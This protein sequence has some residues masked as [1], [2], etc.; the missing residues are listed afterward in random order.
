MPAGGDRILASDATLLEEY[1]IRKPL[2]RLI[3]QTAQSLAHNTQTAIQYGTSSESIDTH[4]WHDTSV[5][6]TRIT[7]QFAGYFTIRVHTHMATA[8]GTNYTQVTASIAVNG[9]RVDPQFFMRPDAASNSG[10]TAASFT[11]IQLAAGDYVEHFAS[12]TNGTSSAQN[13]SASAGFRSVME[14]VFERPI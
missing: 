8:S 4:G 5:N 11:L 1:T 12:Q 14:L 13:T 6:N 2:V 10:A 3:A 9:T 7:V